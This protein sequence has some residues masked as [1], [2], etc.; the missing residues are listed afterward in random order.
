MFLMISLPDETE[1]DAIRTKE[2]CLELSKYV[3]SMSLAVTQIL[4]GTEL[5]R[6]AFQKGILPKDFSYFDK[7]FYHTYTQF[8]DPHIPL[9]FELLNIEFVEKLFTQIMDIKA[10]KYDKLS[11]LFRKA[12]NGIFSLHKRPLKKNLIYIR[13]F[14]M[15]IFRK[16]QT[17]I[18]S[19]S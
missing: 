2:A 16:I 18:K 14:G 4:P 13:R 7:R 19:G 10:Q 1:E 5:E 6:I 12:N 9:Y 15:A 8:C 3:T 17:V 11:D